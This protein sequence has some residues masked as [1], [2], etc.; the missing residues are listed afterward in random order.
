MSDVLLEWRCDVHEGGRSSS[1]N[2]YSSL[3]VYLL[4][5]IDFVSFINFKRCVVICAHVIWSYKTATQ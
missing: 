4:L 1:C 3:Q 5:F 2:K